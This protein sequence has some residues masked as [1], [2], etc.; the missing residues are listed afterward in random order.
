MEK[1]SEIK[2]TFLSLLDCLPYAC[3]TAWQYE[4]GMDIHKCREIF[5]T[6]N[7][8]CK[9]SVPK[10][11]AEVS[12]PQGLF[13]VRFE[14]TDHFR[15]KLI[16]PTIASFAPSCAVFL[17]RFLSE[18]TVEKIT[19]NRKT[20]AHFLAKEYATASDKSKYYHWMQECCERKILMHTIIA[21]TWVIPTKDVHQEEWI[22]NY[23]SS[24]FET[25]IVHFS[26]EDAPYDILFKTHSDLEK[27][28]VEAYFEYDDEEFSVFN[29]P[30]KPEDFK[31]P[32]E[33]VQKFKD[34]YAN[35]DD[36]RNEST[37]SM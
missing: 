22:N 25:N 9:L 24:P 37:M 33:I 27:M 15:L 12:S 30:L 1:L 28:S 7:V 21:N 32:E 29:M 26:A 20:L 8:N 6:L 19:G 34:G 5:D 11:F 2:D 16:S 36:F 35:F 13:S 14:L 17:D 4:N 23:R 31:S 3:V 10:S 18:K